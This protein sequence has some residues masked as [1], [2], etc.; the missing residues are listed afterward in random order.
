MACENEWKAANTAHRNLDIAESNWWSA[1]FNVGGSAL[2]TIGAAAATAA[3]AETGVGL[4]AGAAATAG[5]Y[6]WYIGSLFALDAAD[7]AEDMAQEAY[8]EAMAAYCDCL[9]GSS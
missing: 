2:C 6:S 4:A 7:E 9:H 8:D 5:S 3:T 1:A